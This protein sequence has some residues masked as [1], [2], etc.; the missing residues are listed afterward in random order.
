[1][2]LLSATEGRLLS[3]LTDVAAS[4]LQRLLARAD[5]ERVRILLGLLVAVFIAFRQRPLCEHKEL[6]AASLER[7]ALSGTWL[8]DS[9]A[10]FSKLQAEP[11]LW[12]V[13]LAPVWP[14]GASERSVAQALEREAERAGGAA[15]LVDRLYWAD[16]GLARP[17]Q[18]CYTSVRAVREAALAAAAE[19]RGRGAA[20]ASQPGSSTSLSSLDGPRRSLCC[21]A[22]TPPAHEAEARRAKPAQRTLREA[23]TTSERFYSEPPILE[24]EEAPE[25]RDSVKAL[26]GA[27]RVWSFFRSLVGGGRRA[28]LAAAREHEKKAAE[29]HAGMQRTAR[30]DAE[31][32][33]AGA[34]PVVQPSWSPEPQKY[35]F[36][37]PG[38][39][40][41]AEQVV[42]KLADRVKIRQRLPGMSEYLMN[43]VRCVPETLLALSLTSPP[44]CQRKLWFA[45][46]PFSRARMW[47]TNL[48]AGSVSAHLPT[49]L[50]SCL[51][52]TPNLFSLMPWRAPRT[53]A[54]CLT[55]SNVSGE[56]SLARLNGLLAGETPL[57]AVD[58]GEVSKNLLVADAGNRRLTNTGVPA[59]LAG[60]ALPLNLFH[61]VAVSEA[62]QIECIGQSFHV[63]V[64]MLMA[65]AALHG[66]LLPALQSKKHIVVVSWFDGIGSALI[67]LVHLYRKG[68]FKGS[69]VAFIHYDWDAVCGEVVSSWFEREKGLGGLGGFTLF[70][71]TSDIADMQCATLHAHLELAGGGASLYFAGAATLFRVATPL[72]HRLTPFRA[73]A[74]CQDLSWLN[75]YAQ[76]MFGPKSIHFFDFTTPVGWCEL[77]PRTW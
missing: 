66:P 63:G 72:H 41:I 52:P 14:A 15:S 60:Q 4:E 73:G 42:T 22:P 35:S 33:T 30:M 20:L 21:A 62:K 5:V 48:P 7:L 38:T 8:E 71:Y 50:V 67:A 54:A 40:L 1:M 11:R 6:V 77:V 13:L 76:G 65:L 29:L 57:S 69:T 70:V 24:E 23:L 56:A 55:C 10:V 17:V 12:A 43:P 36:I 49:D 18:P 59:R 51:P 44:L 28:E 25:V 58:M 3:R 19:L 68:Y 53:P 74:P 2:L 37:K 45:L 46:W 27:T 31:R 47:T 34:A 61:N 9:R 39:S 16:W 64:T 75:R 32:A 26:A